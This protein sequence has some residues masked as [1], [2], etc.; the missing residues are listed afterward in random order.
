MKFGEFKGGTA[1][2]MLLYASGR[3]R[4]GLGSETRI[5]FVQQ[6]CEADRGNCGARMSCGFRQMKSAQAKSQKKSHPKRS[7]AE[8][9][10]GVA[11]PD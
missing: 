4:P 11:R 7:N 2:Y 5:N 10:I 3:L 1:R 8:N 9:H 6:S